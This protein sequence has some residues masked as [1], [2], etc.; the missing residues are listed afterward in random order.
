M[1]RESCTKVADLG[2]RRL[3]RQAKDTGHHLIE[4]V[5]TLKNAEQALLRSHVAMEEAE[6]QHWGILEEDVL[7]KLR[8]YAKDCERITTGTHEILKRLAAEMGQD[9]PFSTDSSSG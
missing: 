4:S 5:L 9:D 8:Q 3:Q 2:E 6:W 7:V 1:T